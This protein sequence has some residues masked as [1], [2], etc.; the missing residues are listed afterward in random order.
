MPSIDWHIATGTWLVDGTLCIVL[1]TGLG[2]VR[3][4]SLQLAPHVAAM[5]GV[6]ATNM[7]LQTAH[8]R[9]QCNLMD[10]QHIA[11]R[12]LRT[13]SLAIK[14]NSYYKSV[15]PSL[16]LQSCGQ[17]AKIS[18]HSVFLAHKGQ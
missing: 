11:I 14:L 13:D 17:T 10:R 2:S 9:E 12:S 8:I 6:Q 3:H 5:L 4:E 7:C 15:K 1:E 18:T 16:S